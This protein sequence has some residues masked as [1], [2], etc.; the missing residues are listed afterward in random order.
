MLSARLSIDDLQVT[1]ETDQHTW[2]EVTDGKIVLNA[3]LPYEDVEE[4]YACVLPPLLTPCTDLYPPAV[5]A[6][7]AYSS[8]RAQC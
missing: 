3:R 8:S 2:V 6:V 7:D 4:I 5:T 1:G